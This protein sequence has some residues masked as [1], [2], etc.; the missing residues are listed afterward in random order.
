MAAVAASSVATRAGKPSVLNGTRTGPGAIPALRVFRLCHN[1]QKSPS[2]RGRGRG[3]FKAET[4]VRIPVGTPSR[5]GRWP[6]PPVFRHIASRLRLAANGHESARTRSRYFALAFVP[7]AWVF[8]DPL[9]GP[10]LFCRFSPPVCRLPD[11]PPSFDF[12]AMAK[13]SVSVR[14]DETRRSRVRP[15]AFR[16]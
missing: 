15:G 14:A 12:L 8:F 7:E 2:S 11:D 3:P 9:V 1:C 4:R 16:S 10:A 6:P 13:T 5:F